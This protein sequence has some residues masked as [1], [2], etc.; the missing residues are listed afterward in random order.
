[1][2]KPFNFS[3]HAV[4]QTCKPV[5][6][7]EGQSVSRIMATPAPQKQVQDLSTSRWLA[8]IQPWDRKQA[9]GERLFHL[10]HNIYP[11]L[12]G[13]IT[14]MLLECDNSELVVLLDSYELL[15][16][17]VDEAV[18]VLKAYQMVR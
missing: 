6:D 5:I 18:A 10:I 14:G 4:R 2:Q 8:D 15:R 9:L 3:V 17:K 13:K 12:A 1:M 11:D 16:A 7:V